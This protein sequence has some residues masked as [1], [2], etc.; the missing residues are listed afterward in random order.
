M[1]EEGEVDVKDTLFQGEGGKH[2]IIRRFPGIAH[3]FF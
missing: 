1:R 2:I 3:A